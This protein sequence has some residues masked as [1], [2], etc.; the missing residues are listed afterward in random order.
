MA[1]EFA[2]ASGVFLSRDALN[3]AGSYVPAKWYAHSK[4]CNVLF[5]QELSARVRAKNIYVNALNPGGVAT[6]LVQHTMTQIQGWLAFSSHVQRA[7]AWA[8]RWV[9]DTFLWHAEEAALTQLWLA[10]GAEVEDGE[11]LHGRYAVPLA[12]LSWPSALLWHGHARNVGMQKALWAFTEDV[13]GTGPR[14]VA[15][16]LAANEANDGGKEEL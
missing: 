8:Q 7:I 1:H 10:T 15:E 6:Q 12:R 2:P 4:L 9:F 3:D 16:G 5:A 11:G 14:A 13:T